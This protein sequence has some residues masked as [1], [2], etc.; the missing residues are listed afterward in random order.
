[1]KGKISIIIPV[2]NREQYL[3]ECLESILAQTY[4]NFEVILID[5]G[6]TD[7]TIDIC[8]HYSQQDARFRLYLIEHGGVSVA[9]NKGLAE[10]RGEYVFFLDSDDVIHPFLLETLVK[11]MEEKKAAMGGT[12]IINVQ[13]TYWHKV[14]ER[15]LERSGEARVTYQ[16]HEETLHAMFC[17]QSPLSEI[18]GVIFRKDLIG[19]TKFKEDLYIGE[20]FWFIYENLIKHADSVFV[21]KKWYYCRSHPHNSS[22][23]FKFTGFYN[24]FYRRRLVWESEE[25]F[26]RI[27]YANRQ[28]RQAFGMYIMCMKKNKPYSVEA[29]KMR[30]FIKTQK[31]CLFI[32]M[33]RK[34]KVK[35]YLSLWFPFVCK[36]FR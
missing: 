23:D 16:N 28:K 14:Q 1:M 13:E 8:K 19:D 30:M 20:D 11:G 31:R 26:G 2:Y 5:D 22:W 10:V 3:E 21:D 12:K 17:T 34:E 7:C 32:A 24:R 35:Y 33:T 18:G 9:R 4:G 29:K 15:I 27:E 6:S 25:K 36:H